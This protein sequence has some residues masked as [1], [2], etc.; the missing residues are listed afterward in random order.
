MIEKPKSLVSEVL[1]ESDDMLDIFSM[2][3]AMSKLT[4]LLKN[5]PAITR[6]ESGENSAASLH[7]RLV[8]IM[9]EV[10]ETE[11]A[12]NYLSNDEGFTLDEMKNNLIALKLKFNAQ[13]IVKEYKKIELSIGHKKFKYINFSAGAAWGEYAQLSSKYQADKF[14]QNNLSDAEI[15]SAVI[16]K[17]KPAFYLGMNIIL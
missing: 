4:K 3:P 17:I 12:Y 15:S 6:G 10:A 9:K 13:S 16:K 2:T 8:K 5:P 7:K 11:A 14:I 1:K